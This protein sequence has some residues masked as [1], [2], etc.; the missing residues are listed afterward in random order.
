MQIKWTTSSRPQFI[1]KLQK[2]VC[3]T[4]PPALMM[5]NSVTSLSV[6]RFTLWVLRISVFSHQQWHTPPSDYMMKNCGGRCCKWKATV[7]TVLFY[8][9]LCRQQYLLG[10]NS[11]QPF[12]YR[13]GI[14]IVLSIIHK[15]LY[16][17]F[18][19]SLTT[20]DSLKRK[21]QGCRKQ[22][23]TSLWPSFKCERDNVEGL[24]VPGKIIDL[25]KLTTFGG[26]LES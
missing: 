9:G 15:S 7:H 26:P 5:M 13:I 25:T 18:V 21:C 16:M 17:R 19:T 2:D 14:S 6:V 1:L 3:I 4:H 10:Q 23:T 22:G 11:I 8:G 12:F 20:A 24:W